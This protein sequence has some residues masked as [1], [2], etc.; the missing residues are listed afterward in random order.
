MN[1]GNYRAGLTGLVMTKKVRINMVVFFYVYAWTIPKYSV[2][3]IYIPLHW[4][5]SCIFP[6]DAIFADR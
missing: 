1:N 5:G 6:D 3:S 4:I 2:L